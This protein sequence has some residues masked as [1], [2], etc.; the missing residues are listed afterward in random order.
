MKPIRL[1]IKKPVQNLPFRS[2]LKTAKSTLVTTKPSRTQLELF[3]II[4]SQ[5]H[6]FYTLRNLTRCSRA[7]ESSKT[8]LQTPKCLKIHTIET[9]SCTHDKHAFSTI[10]LDNDV[11]QLSGSTDSHFVS[12]P[13]QEFWN[14]NRALASPCPLSV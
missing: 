7:E 6:K 9:D 8:V 12:S 1:K 3:S 4:S 13:V 11:F 14:R 5:I 10:I 2:Y